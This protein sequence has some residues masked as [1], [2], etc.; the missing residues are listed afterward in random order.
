M[1]KHRVVIY[2]ILLFIVALALYLRFN[3]ADVCAGIG[4]YYYKNNN[5]EKAQVFYEKAFSYGYADSETREAYVNS[6]INSPLSLEAQEKLVSIAEDSITDSASVKAKYFLYDIR[7]EIHREYPLN[8]IK[9]ASYNGKILRWSKFPITYAF[10]NPQMAPSDYVEEIKNAF[11]EWEREGSVMFS[12][13]SDKNANI[14]IEF[15]QNK[16]IDPEFGRKYVIAY[17]VPV[18]N[19]NKLDGMVIR[20]YMQSP[21]GES[22]SRNQ[23]YNTA[24]HEIFHALGFM[25]HSYEP[26][27]VMYLA[28][29]NQTIIDDTRV[30][31]TEADVSTLK[32]LYKIK[33]DITNR[34]D[35]KS[36]YLSYLVLGDEEDVNLSKTREAKHYISQAPSLPGGYIDLAETFVAQKKYPE[37]IKAL[38]KALTLADNDETRYII[39]YNLAVSYYYINHMDMAFEYINEALK[40]KDTEELHYIM[41]EIYTKTNTNKAITEYKYLVQKSPDNL[42]YAIRLANIYIKQYNYIKARRV[43]KQFLRNNPQEKKNKRLSAYGVLLF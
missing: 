20:F 13:A 40:I 29:D 21:D 26:G 41:A 23:I 22:F 36:E 33:P 32:L 27:N 34:G 30:E 37:A 16:F 35:L 38:E 6:I 43:L 14:K 25:G 3:I 2:T 28:K 12:E 42:D 15:V 9:Q 17:T 24:L 5:I 7:R 11:L 19:M 39:Y 1:T 10:I 18:L 8:Y 4:N 31:L